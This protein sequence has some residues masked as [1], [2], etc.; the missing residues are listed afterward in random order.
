MNKNAIFTMP[1][2]CCVPGCKSNYKSDYTPI[3]SFP[4]AEER[5]TLWKKAI[6]RENL[7]VTKNSGV[8]II[9]FPEDQIVREIRGTRR[10]GKF[11]IHLHI[12]GIMY[13]GLSLRF[14]YCRPILRLEN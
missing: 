7:T 8:C 2:S 4:S 11:C 3:F 5:L 9:H 1:R 14:F 6:P 13:V 10:D 12:T